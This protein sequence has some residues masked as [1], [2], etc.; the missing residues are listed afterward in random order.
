MNN[1]SRKFRRPTMTRQTVGV[2]IGAFVQDRLCP[3]ARHV[4]PPVS[5]TVQLG[6]ESTVYSIGG[7]EGVAL[8]VSDPFVGVVFGRQRGTLRILQVVHKRRHGMARGTRMYGLG[9]F[10]EQSC[11]VHERERGQQE[12]T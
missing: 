3:R 4:A 5:Q 6:M 9:L 11:R 8:V 1:L 12:Q 10:K 7:M 2:G